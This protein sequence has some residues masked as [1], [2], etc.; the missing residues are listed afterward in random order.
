MMIIIVSEISSVI[1]LE[2]QLRIFESFHAITKYF[3]RGQ[4]T[5]LKKWKMC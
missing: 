3:K 2:V 4:K 5:Y 1:F